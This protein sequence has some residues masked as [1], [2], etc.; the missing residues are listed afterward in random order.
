M[1]ANCVYLRGG[2]PIPAV[3]ETFLSCDEDIKIEVESGNGFPGRGGCYYGTG[4]LYVSDRRLLFI[5]AG[6]NPQFNSFSIPYCLLKKFKLKTPFFSSAYLN[7]EVRPVPHGGLNGNGTIILK[8]ENA[9]LM[10]S[11]YNLVQQQITVFKVA[12]D[13][14]PWE[15]VGRMSMLPIHEIFQEQ[16]PEQQENV[17]ESVL[18]QLQVRQ[19]QPILQQPQLRP[20]RTMPIQ[21]VPIGFNTSIQNEAPA[22]VRVSSLMSQTRISDSSRPYGLLSPE[23]ALPDSINSNN[24]EEFQREGS[25]STR[26]SSSEMREPVENSAATPSL[27]LNRVVSR[28]GVVIINRPASDSYA[29]PPDLIHP[30]THVDARGEGE[31]NVAYFDANNTGDIVLQLG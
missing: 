21:T 7:G 11:V 18:Q 14:E 1:A 27:H 23:V 30:A 24:E 16:F 29:A 8:F 10:R 31:E 15:R 22:V 5:R 26:H 28:P 6:P 17:R 3:G 25:R 19:P 2:N 12:V 13:K 4:K 9:E 20:Q